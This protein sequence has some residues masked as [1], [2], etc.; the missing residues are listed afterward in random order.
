MAKKQTDNEIIDELATTTTP[1][2]TLVVE[3]I[4][5]VEE[6]AVVKEP[7]VVEKPKAAPAPKVAVKEPG[8]YHNGRKIEAVPAKVGK[9]WVI[10]VEGQREKVLKSEIEFVA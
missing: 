9:K 2:E 3:K 7:V 4:P 8:M 5:V 1:E 6:V 10:L